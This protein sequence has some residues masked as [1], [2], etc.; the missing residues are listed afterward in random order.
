[1]LFWFWLKRQWFCAE[2][3]RR[4]S[5]G[6]AAINRRKT[7]NE[8]N[9]GLK[10]ITDVKEFDRVVREIHASGITDFEEITEIITRDYRHLIREITEAEKEEWL[11]RAKESLVEQAMAEINRE[12]I[13]ETGHLAFV[14]LRIDGVP[15]YKKYD[16]FSQA[17]IAELKATGIIL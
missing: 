17:E 7:M 14:F 15:G 9:D 16:A 8:K 1:M 2:A 5:L 3:A 6:N 12:S 4:K 11:N 13:K 10:D